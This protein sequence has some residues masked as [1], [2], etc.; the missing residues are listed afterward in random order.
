MTTVSTVSSANRTI[1][2]KQI[3]FRISPDMRDLEFCINVGE[4]KLTVSEPEAK[5]IAV[6]IMSFFKEPVKE[7]G[8]S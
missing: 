6:I 8:E 5:Q 7:G 4:T 3:D 2:I 1:S